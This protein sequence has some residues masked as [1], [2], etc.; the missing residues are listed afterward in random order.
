MAFLISPGC[1][2]TLDLK[3]EK[4][5]DRLGF[6]NEHEVLHLSYLPL[7]PAAGPGFRG[8]LIWVRSAGNSITAGS[9]NGYKIHKDGINLSLRFYKE[10]PAIYHLGHPQS[11]PVPAYCQP[12]NR[13]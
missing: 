1:L 3:F 13:Y 12:D 8:G 10:Y 6:A 4:T 5:K 2:F 9:I 7:F 11:R